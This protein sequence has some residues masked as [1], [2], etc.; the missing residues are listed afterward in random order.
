MNTVNNTYFFKFKR[1]FY[2]GINYKCL[3]VHPLKYFYRFSLHSID[4]F[5]Q[6]LILFN[7]RIKQENKLFF[8]TQTYDSSAR[9]VNYSNYSAEDVFPIF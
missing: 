1:Y 6:L 2:E 4:G 5:K 3:Y 9:I 8:Q 7:L